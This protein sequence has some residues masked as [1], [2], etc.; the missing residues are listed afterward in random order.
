MNPQAKRVDDQVLKDPQN[1]I[2]LR[3]REAHHVR[4]GSF[5]TR[6]SRQQSPPCPLC[7]E[8]G[9]K[10]RAFVRHRPTIVG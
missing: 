1:A 2:S 9:S 8:S 4:S 10:F 3:S 6:S 7:I 5:A